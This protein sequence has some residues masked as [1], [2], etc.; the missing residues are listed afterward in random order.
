MSHWVVSSVS[1]FAQTLYF[2]GTLEG[3][4]LL[5]LQS[6]RVDGLTQL[7]ALVSAL[8]SGSI[9]WVLIALLLFLFEEQRGNGIILLAA[10]IIA[11]IVTS[12]AASF[13]GRACPADSVV[14]LVGVVGVSKSGFSMPSLHA[15]TAFAATYI[16]ARGVGKG[17]GAGAF[18][19]ALII[20]FARMY[21]GVAYLSDILVGAV[22]GTVI[23]AVLFA[24]LGKVFQVIDRQPKRPP[25]RKRVT[26]THGSHSR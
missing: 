3:S 14:G 18:F 7:L 10:L 8:G 21:L 23:A 17:P 13:I 11:S 24:L 16:I 9:L 4:I 19:V 25:R 6:I 1:V 20:C 26:R 15:S 2:G 5:A 22:L 12:M